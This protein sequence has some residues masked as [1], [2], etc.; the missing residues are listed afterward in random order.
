MTPILRIAA[1]RSDDLVELVGAHEGQ[2]GV[3]L[4][5]VQPR[6]HAEDGVAEADVQAAFRH[7][8]FVRAG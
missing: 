2:H 1:A 5:V 4:V 6:L 8:E 7:A 3:A